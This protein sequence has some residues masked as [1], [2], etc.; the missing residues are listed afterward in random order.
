MVDAV[1]SWEVPVADPVVASVAVEAFPEVAGPGVDSAQAYPVV[2]VAVVP[3][4]RT[5]EVAYPFPAEVRAAFVAYQVPVGALSGSAVVA[6]D[7]LQEPDDR[8][9]RPCREVPAFLRPGLR[10]SVVVEEVA[11]AFHPVVSFALFR[12]SQVG[13]EVELLRGEVLVEDSGQAFPWAV[14]RTV[15]GVAGLLAG[16]SHLRGLPDPS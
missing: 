6:K 11:M 1:A 13:A 4:D 8:E 10:Y 16:T 2:G 14:A 5:V 9:D 3:E 7:S 12:A 15:V